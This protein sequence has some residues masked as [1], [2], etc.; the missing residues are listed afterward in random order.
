MARKLTYEEKLRRAEDRELARI[1]RQ[2][3]AEQRNRE[4][5]IKRQERLVD[6]VIKRN[7]AEIQ[8]EAI[9]RQSKKKT[10]H[11][12]T[13]RMLKKVWRKLI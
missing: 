8:K 3:V 12:K 4:K 5:E 6:L 2:E 7:Q 9:R 11:R 13:K 10:S 1:K